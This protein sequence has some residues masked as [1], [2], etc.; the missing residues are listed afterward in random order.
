MSGEGLTR[1]LRLVLHQDTFDLFIA[2]PL[3]DLQRAPTAAAYLTIWRTALG[4]LQVDIA[5]DIG[6]VAQDATLLAGLVGMQA[7]YYG[8]LLLVLVGHVQVRDIPG[9]LANGSGPLTLAVAAGVVL[10]SSVPTLFCF[11][12]PRRTSEA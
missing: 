2:P 12:P 3:A 6:I 11:W 4:A 8:G 7:C 5:S 9:Y 10:A 1:V